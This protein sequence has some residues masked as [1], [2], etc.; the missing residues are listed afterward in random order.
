M[1]II[2]SAFESPEYYAFREHVEKSSSENS[3]KI[4][5]NC[6]I[7]GKTS[8][9][10]PSFMSVDDVVMYLEEQ[11]RDLLIQYNDLY[12]KIV[13][14]EYPNIFQKKYESIVQKVTIIDAVMDEIHSYVNEKN[15][16]RVHMPI[17]QIIENIAANKANA[18]SLYMNMNEDV[19]LEKKKI[20]TLLK[21]HKEN[22]QL[23]QNLI[24]AKCAVLYE[25]VIY[26][27]NTTKSSE[28]PLN[29]HT[30]EGKKERKTTRK[31][32]LAKKQT[33]KETVKKL[34]IEKLI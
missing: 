31:T 17:M 34:M 14:A 18:A 12:D 3:I 22:A 30:Q 24:D 16:V 7:Y 6:I 32:N 11:K 25:Y 26:K 8:K 15:D 29:V 9:V 20:K 13:I 19:H 1:T 21:I 23:E 28:N 2:S 33:I 10:I 5:D 27:T 4:K